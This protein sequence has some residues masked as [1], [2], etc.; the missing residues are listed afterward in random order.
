MNW[1]SV[2]C[3]AITNMGLVTIALTTDD[4]QTKGIC[5]GAIAGFSIPPGTALIGSMNPRAAQRYSEPL[6]YRGAGRSSPS[7]SSGDA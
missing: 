1:A 3:T 2:W 6:S 7:K 4:P 5:V